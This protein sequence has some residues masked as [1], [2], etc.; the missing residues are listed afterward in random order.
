M[1]VTN[2]ALWT[3]GPAHYRSNQDDLACVSCTASVTEDQFCEGC[4]QALCISCRTTI[5]GEPHCPACAADLRK[6]RG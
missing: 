5:Q 4:G 2:L 3:L 1:T 6:G